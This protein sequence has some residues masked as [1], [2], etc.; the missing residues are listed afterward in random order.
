MQSIAV[1]LQKLGLWSPSTNTYPHRRDAG[2]SISRDCNRRTATPGAALR[3][4]GLPEK[5][6]ADWL[7]AGQ[8]TLER[9]ATLEAAAQFDRLRAGQQAI[10][11]EAVAQLQKGLDELTS[12]PDEPW[13][14]QQELA[15]RIALRR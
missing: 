12:L 3:R 6:V 10:E 13:R 11:R 4:G 9:S 1:W 14:Q 8:R 2:E 5:P 7:R 15:L